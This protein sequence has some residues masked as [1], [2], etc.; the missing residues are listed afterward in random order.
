MWFVQV[1]GQELHNDAR[2]QSISEVE[3]IINSHSNAIPPDLLP[4]FS[5]TY[6][7]NCYAWCPVLDRASIYQSLAGSPLVSNA[8]ALAASHVQPPMLPHDGPVEYYKRA[9]R[10]FYEDEE[11]N[12]ISCLKALL[13]FYWW[14]PRS[15][16]AVHRH[17]SWWWTSLV[18]RQAQWMNLHRDPPMDTQPDD[19]GLRRRIWW[20]AF[21]RERLTALCQS[22]PAIID[23]RDCSVQEPTLSDFPANMIEPDRVKAEV[24]IYWVRLCDTI[25]RTAQHLSR[26]PKIASPFPRVLADELITWSKSLPPHLI[27]PIEASHTHMFNKDVHQLYLPYLCTVIVL[28]LKRP[29]GGNALP[30]AL[31]PAIMAATCVARIF[32]DILARGDTRFLMA[33]TSWY[34]GVTFVALLSASQDPALSEAA[35]ADL[36]IVVL[37]CKQLGNMWASSIVIYNGFD[38]LRKAAT[39]EGSE[40]SIPTQAAEAL[41]S[42]NGAAYAQSPT[43]TLYT[44]GSLDWMAY[45]GFV[46]RDTSR[47]ASILI[48]SKDNNEF[49][50]KA[51]LPD[52]SLLDL[53]DWFSDLRGTEFVLTDDVAFV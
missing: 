19:I 1:Y 10:M 8:L 14:A 21:A 32:R 9:R 26:T 39:R 31:P 7:E 41:M 45:F 16:A 35:N 37:L 51:M 23:S 50:L 34:C 44:P 18:I 43:E 49:G 33:I 4:I 47:L 53:Q 17:S 52:S 2:N 20:T 5:E 11:P 15:T 27:L 12:L 30:Q 22:K 38:R 25:G 36:D 42:I 28:H 46:T 6:F 24:F 29:C 48:A 13:L 3:R 40:G